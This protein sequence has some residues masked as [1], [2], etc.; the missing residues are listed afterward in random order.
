MTFRNQSIRCLANLLS[1]GLLVLPSIAAPLPS[2]GQT[3]GGGFGVQ[4]KEWRITPEELDDIKAM[5]A[6]YLRFGYPW[7]AIEHKKG[8]YDWSNA[9]ALMKEIRAR[10]LRVIYELNGFHEAYSKLVD[11]A[12]E[13][14]APPPISLQLPEAPVSSEALEAFKRFAAET[15]RRYNGQDVIWEIWNEPDTNGGWPPKADGAAFTSFLSAICSAI[16]DAVP[17]ATV[18]GP[19]LAYLPSSAHWRPD[20]LGTILKSPAA[21]CLDALSIHP[22]RSTP[23]ETVSDDYQAMRTFINQH[24]PAGKKPLPFINSEWGYSLAAVTPEQQAAYTARYVLLNNLE[25]IPASIWYEWRDSGS[26][27]GLYDAERHFGLRDYENRGKPS[28]NTLKEFL[29][30]VRDAVVERRLAAGEARDYLLLLRQP[31]GRQLLAAWSL[32]KA[33]IRIRED[34]RDNSYA[35]SEDPVLIPLTSPDSTIDVTSTGPE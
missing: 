15:V 25:R 13:D 28:Y 34:S 20:F 1:L 6:A 24:T 12:P 8:S 22:Y 19:A 10:K 3:I 32:R 21:S 27:A 9:D 2:N 26:E 31:D 11:V 14:P 5:G 35:L 16:K 7:N 23:P 18:I 4:V 30:R 17:E 29:P 33:S